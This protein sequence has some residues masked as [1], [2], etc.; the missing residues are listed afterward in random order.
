MQE[1]FALHEIILDAKGEPIDYRFLEINKA[2]EKITGLKAEDVKNKTIKEVLPGTE[3]I[4]LKKYGKV[5]LERKPMTF[6]NYSKELDKYFNINVYSPSPNQFATIFTDITF[7]KRYQEKIKAERKFFETTINSIGDGVISTDVEGKIIIMNKVAEKLTGWKVS[8][9]KGKN[10]KKVFNI[11]HEKTGE[12]CEEYFEKVI[13][14]GKLIELQNHT[15]LIKKSKEQI[16]IEDSASPILDENGKIN[17]AVIV[18][19]DITEKKEKQEKI[20]YLSYHDHLTSLYNRHFFEEQIRRLDVQRNLP[21]TIA[22][23]DVNGLKMVNDVFGHEA[24]DQLLRRVAYILRKQSRADDIISRFGG[25]EFVILLPRTKNKEAGELMNRIKDALNQE[26]NEKYVISLSMGW[27]TKDDVSQDRKEIFDLAEDLMYRK[28]VTE[29]Q[30]MRVQTINLIVKSF[31]E[32]NPS[33]KLHSE[34][35]SELCQKIGKKMNLDQETLRELKVAGLL[36]DIGKCIVDKK[37]LYKSGKL[38]SNEFEEIR[39]H[40][41]T[42]YRILKS[43]DLYSSVAEYILSH[44]EWWNGGGYPRGLS[45]DDISLAGRI[46]AVA[47]AYQYMIEERPYKETYSHERAINEIKNWAG[48]Q[49]DPEIVQYI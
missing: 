27:A 18:F 7:E 8:E 24:G 43:A 39:K 29:S 17:G 45:S 2:F 49:F 16:S 5:A 23:L 4:Y 3:E 40:A 42:G 46:L 36:H 12:K 38:T 26:K 33:E 22:M 21:L 13:K 25:D 41:E 37:I 48:T 35:V 19:R 10:V 47:E 30:E 44:H 32:E 1:G 11:I 14:E 34:K 20:N 6:S 15:V 28:K 9:A 31:H